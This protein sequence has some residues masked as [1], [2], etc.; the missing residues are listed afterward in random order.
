MKLSDFFH[1]KKG[2]AAP[3]ADSRTPRYRVLGWAG[4]HFFGKFD[5]ASFRTGYLNVWL[6]YSDLY[7]GFLE[8]HMNG[9]F[10]GFEFVTMRSRE[11]GQPGTNIIFR[12]EPGSHADIPG[13][14]ILPGESVMGIKDFDFQCRMVVS[15]RPSLQSVVGMVHLYEH[16][17]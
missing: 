16:E 4:N 11:D 7:E 13:V 1:R 8:K 5:Q 2:D 12:P 17:I 14:E 10:S 9:F 3:A 15:Y 6:E